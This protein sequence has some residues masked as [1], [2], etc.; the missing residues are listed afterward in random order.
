MDIEIINYNITKGLQYSNLTLKIKVNKD[1]IDYDI[2]R[3]VINSLRRTILTNIPQY[4]FVPELMQFEKNTTIIN[5][6]QYRLKFS[7]I[8]ILN[9][10][11]DII[12][13]DKIENYKE[14]ITSNNTLNTNKIE[15]YIN[16]TNPDIFI[17]NVTTND[18]T[19]MIDNERVDNPYNKEYP[20]LLTKLKK[21]EELQCK[22]IGV[23]GT[24]DNN[25]IWSS[26]TNM[27]FTQ[28]ET[29]K[30]YTLIINSNGQINEF[31]IIDKACQKIIYDLKQIENNIYLYLDTID[32]FDKNIH[33]I[34]PNLTIGNLINIE[35]QNNKNVKFS[36]ICK[37]T[38][39]QNEVIINIEFD[40]NIF[41]TEN[42]KDN[43]KI[44]KSV[45]N[46]CINNLIEIYTKLNL[47][48][49]K[50]KIL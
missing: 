25:N 15:I 50:K 12:N 39:L 17:K 13:L 35:L 2:L 22:L 1:G 32:D 30:E 28:D 31:D 33:I 29:T 42:A 20:I 45:F 37:S 9:I 26:V 10:T 48:V 24:A 49:Q 40:I 38:F 47:Q 36:G 41:E 14:F 4:A 19:Y 34:L 27:H 3:I 46:V 21:N 16:Q 23:I 7:Q 18:I 11:N 43:F 44:I 5:N 8:P 6:D